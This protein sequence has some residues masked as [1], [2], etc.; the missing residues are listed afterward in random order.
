MKAIMMAA[1]LGLGLAGS[2]ATAS[3]Q[4]YGGS[5][6]GYRGRD[7]GYGSRD[8]GERSGD[9]RESYGERGGYGERDRGYRGGGGFDEA[10]YLRC[11]P[12]VRRAVSRGQMESAAAH[13]RVF[14]R[15]EGR[16]LTCG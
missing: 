16:R 5:D 10:E 12:D 6:Y 4:G 13:Y 1:A 3:A 8:R 7:D 9:R 14:G 2:V 15:R 11:N